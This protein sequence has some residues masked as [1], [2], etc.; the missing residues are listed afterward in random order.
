MQEAYALL[1]VSGPRAPQDRQLDLLC[2]EDQC[3]GT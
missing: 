3:N 2:G 1:G